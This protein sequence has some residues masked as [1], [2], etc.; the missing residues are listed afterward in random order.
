MLLRLILMTFLAV[1]PAMAADPGWAPYVNARFGT[2]ADVPAGLLSPLPPPDNGDGMAFESAD[3]AVRLTIFGRYNV[4]DRNLSGLKGADLDDG[5]YSDVTYQTRGDDWYVL[6]GYD[7]GRIFYRKVLLSA[8]GE[9]VHT[10]QLDYPPEE[11]D[12]W[13]PLVKHIADSLHYE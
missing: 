4:F 8:D 1:S 2:A 3:G 11:R 12:T 13:D 10:L 7:G 6:S 9:V 5:G